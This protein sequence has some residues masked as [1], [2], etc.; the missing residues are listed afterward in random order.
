MEVLMR[1]HESGTLRRSR[2]QFRGYA[3]LL[4]GNG[5]GFVTEDVP[6]GFIETANAVWRATV[7]QLAVFLGQLQSPSGK[8]KRIDALRSPLKIA[9]GFEPQAL[10]PLLCLRRRQRRIA[11]RTSDVLPRAP[12]QQQRRQQTT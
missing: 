10:G 12:C 3:D 11:R 2:R 7:A 5:F 4:A 9:G 8:T 1:D 6:P